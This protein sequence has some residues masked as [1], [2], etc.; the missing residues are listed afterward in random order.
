[1]SYPVHCVAYGYEYRRIEDCDLA[2]IDIGYGSFAL[3]HNICK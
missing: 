1:M 3:W 2:M